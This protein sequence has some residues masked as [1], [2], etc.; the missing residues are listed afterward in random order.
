MS[1]RQS[2][3]FNRLLVFA[4]SNYLKQLHEEYFLCRNEVKV[5]NNIFFRY[6]D[7]VIPCWVLEPPE[8]LIRRDQKVSSPESYRKSSRTENPDFTWHNYGRLG[9]R[10][11]AFYQWILDEIW[12]SGLLVFL[13][14]LSIKLAN[15]LG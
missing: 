3:L 10:L 11:I 9:E 12:L 5:M 4:I 2:N 15:V 8:Q 7:F 14:W 1:C 13:F 6:C